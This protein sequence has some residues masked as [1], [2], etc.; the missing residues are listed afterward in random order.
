MKRQGKDGETVFGE[1]PETSGVD[2]DGSGGPD[3]DPKKRRFGEE[4]VRR[5]EGFGK[6]YLQ[7]LKL[8]KDFTR[9]DFIISEVGFRQ[10][11][12]SIGWKIFDS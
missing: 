7:V 3:Q 4:R 9:T 5:R 2:G 1:S 6:V 10:E 11:T 8:I 12:H